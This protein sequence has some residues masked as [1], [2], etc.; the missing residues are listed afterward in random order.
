MIESFGMCKS[1]LDHSVL[2]KRFESGVF[3]I[4]LNI[5]NIVIIGD[6]ALGVQSPKTFLHHQVQTKDLGIL[7]YFLGIEVIRI[8]KRIL[9]S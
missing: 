7:K 2:F 5:N 4:V 6:D 9:L 3:L 1:T 8:K